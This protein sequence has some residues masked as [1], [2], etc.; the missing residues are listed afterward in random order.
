[1]AKISSRRRGLL[2]DP[3]QVLNLAQRWLETA[4]RQW[5]WL[6]AALVVVVV[7][8]AAW[9]IHGRM[10]AAREDRAAAALVQLRPKLGAEAPEAAAK[11][12]KE[13]IAKYPGTK[14]ASEA[15]LLRANLLYR[16]KN[17]AE[18]AKSYQALLQGG[19]PGWSTLVSESLSY[20]YEGLGDYKKAA[21][22]LQPVADQS[23]GG[24]HAEVVQRLAMLYEKAGQPGEAA[25]YWKKL[26]DQAPNPV[27]LSYLKERLSEAEAA[28]KTPKK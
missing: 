4:R 16:M 7:V 17:Y 3:E 19:D 27:L 23:T 14:T 21:E 20:C 9:G 24:F 6:A 12:L 15:E 25:V 1:M 5:K 11:V 10:Q 28:A 13:M 8:F 26:L 18:A 2:E 22:S